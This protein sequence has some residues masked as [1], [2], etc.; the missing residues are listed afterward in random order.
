MS[1]TFK[2]PSIKCEGCVDTIT[3]EIK[4]HDENA[5]VKGDVEKKTIEVDSEMSEESVKESITIT[6]HEVG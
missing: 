3:K 4:V 5:K 1:M 2:V 6:G